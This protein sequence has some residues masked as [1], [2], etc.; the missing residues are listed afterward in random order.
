MV[1]PLTRTT[2]LPVRS[3]AHNALLREPAP[4]TNNSHGPSAASG[5][6]GVGNAVDVG[7]V[8]GTNSV[9]VGIGVGKG[10]GVSRAA[11]GVIA[12][13]V[14]ATVAVSGAEAQPARRSTCIASH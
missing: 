3:A 14:G 4:P 5:S 6:A 11:A 1:S 9:D 10:V 12:V 13:A 2:C 8:G 7:G